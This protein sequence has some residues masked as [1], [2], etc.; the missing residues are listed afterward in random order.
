M[1]KF[2]LCMYEELVFTWYFQ[3]EYTDGSRLRE[4]QL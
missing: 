3:L 1:Y 4:E 2:F